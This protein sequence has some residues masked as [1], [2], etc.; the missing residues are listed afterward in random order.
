MIATSDGLLPPLISNIIQKTTFEDTSVQIRINSSNQT[1]I[2]HLYL[3]SIPSLG[4]INE[5]NPLENTISSNTFTYTPNENVYGKDIIE[6][7]AVDVNNLTS[8]QCRV[9]IDIISVN[10]APEIE[11]RFFVLMEDSNINITLLGTDIE[12]SLDKLS[13]E[14]KRNPQNGLLLKD[15]NNVLYIPNENYHG[16]DSFQ[17]ICKDPEGLES[18]MKTIHLEVTPTNDKPVTQD[19]YVE[20]DEDT[21]IQIQLK[22]SDTDFDLDTNVILHYEIVNDTTKGTII[23]TDNF[24]DYTP[25][26]H[27]YGQDQFTYKCID[28]EGLESNISTVYIN[29]RSINDSPILENIYYETNEDESLLISLHEKTFDIDSN[30]FSYT[31]IQTAENGTL[32]P[33][34]NNKITYTPKTNYHGTDYF[35]FQCRD[36]NGELS[37]SAT[38][39]ITINPV[40]D[41]PVAI[42]KN[43]ETNEDTDIGILLEGIDVD[44]DNHELR[45][46]ITKF[47][48]NGKL[49]LIGTSIQILNNEILTSPTI[50]YRPDPNFN[51][52]PLIND[53]STS[54][55][56]GPDTFEYKC[57]DNHNTYSLKNASVI[58]TVIPV[59][60]IAGNITMYNPYSNDSIND[61][62]TLFLIY[63]R[64]KFINT[65][66]KLSIES[67]FDSN[68]DI[69]NI[70][71]S[72]SYFEPDGISN[73]ITVSWYRSTNDID[74]TLF[75]ANKTITHD[76]IS[77]T[78]TS[79]DFN[80]NLKVILSYTDKDGFQNNIEII[81]PQ[82]VSMPYTIYGMFLETGFVKNSSISLL[83]NKKYSYENHF[84]N[85]S[86][87]VDNI[88]DTYEIGEQG[89][90]YTLRVQETQLLDYPYMILQSNSGEDTSTGKKVKWLFQSLI[91]NDKT[92]NVSS[93]V[94]NLN[95]VTTIAFQYFISINNY[96]MQKMID[97][98]N[99]FDVENIL[100]DFNFTSKTE[101]LQLVSIDISLESMKS[102]IREIFETV[103]LLQK[104]NFIDYDENECI[105][106]ILNN[107]YNTPIHYLFDPKKVLSHI[108]TYLYEFI[109]HNHNHNLSTE[110][111][112]ED[113]NEETEFEFE[114][115]LFTRGRYK[116]TSSCYKISNY[117]ILC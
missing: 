20:L 114:K 28:S 53:E 115:K 59:D 66:G 40:N 84:L 81:A 14:I 7:I 22:G 5:L 72:N 4:N 78:I 106:F 94:T 35:V 92:I 100:S 112:I 88:L 74:W 101:L 39:Y 42:D 47:P 77:H 25:E 116:F 85:D 63:N 9:E 64:N 99:L 86:I 23:L 76:A 113:T 8:N 75:D 11:D 54:R 21:N 65:S 13:F 18:S 31:I 44:N 10:D 32:S 48:Q 43:I 29:I 58:I 55:I 71:F 105:I 36:D 95:I 46:Q 57:I 26:T 69:D 17:Y 33:I 52:G 93:T 62:E 12:D 50:I 103:P 51:S 111:I 70:T 110:T 89:E 80:N 49:F 83:T 19:I 79:D 1:G 109:N 67:S 108:Y 73:T 97:L 60:D 6:L 27:V 37:N 45:F 90:E 102:K 82:R 3:H 68:I 24:V 107:L 15:N 2:H 16:N 56:I 61:R 117:I 96:I 30:S 87:S 98:R 41:A 104:N 91:I 38:A 34:I